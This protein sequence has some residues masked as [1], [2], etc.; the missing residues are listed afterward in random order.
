[1]LEIEIDELEERL[2]EVEQEILDCDISDLKQL[3]IEKQNILIKLGKFNFDKKPLPAK[4]KN[5][6]DNFR[7]D[8]FSSKWA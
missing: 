4:T 7:W 6:E 1:M 2:I 8:N 5:N 3:C